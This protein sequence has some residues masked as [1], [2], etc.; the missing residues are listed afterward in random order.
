M[1]LSKPER[2][3]VRRIVLDM[4]RDLYLEEMSNC[5][6]ALTKRGMNEAI[7]E[8]EGRINTRLSKLGCI[9]MIQFPLIDSEEKDPSFSPISKDPLERI[10]TVVIGNPFKEG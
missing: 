9:L 2:R 1:R 6:S 7:E 3:A 10:R 8:L 4:A 5:V